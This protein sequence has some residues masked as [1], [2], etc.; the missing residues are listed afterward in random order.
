MFPGRFR[1]LTAGLGALL[2]AGCSGFPS[3]IDLDE[4]TVVGEVDLGHYGPNAHLLEECVDDRPYY[5]LFYRSRFAMAERLDASG[6]SPACLEQ[7]PAEIPVH[8]VR[9]RGRLGKTGSNLAEICLDGVTYLY[10]DT[11]YT[12]GMAV[13]RTPDGRPATCRVNPAD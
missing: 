2:A 7:A 10:A 1:P 8:A 4:V 3:N 13:K 9:S 5:V 12:A 6:R 11:L